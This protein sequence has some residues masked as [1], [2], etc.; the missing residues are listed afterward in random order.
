MEWT[1]SWLV[2]INETNFVAESFWENEC[3]KRNSEL[4]SLEIENFQKN[5][6]S[7]CVCHPKMP[8]INFISDLKVGRYTLI[9]NSQVIY[10]IRL[11]LSLIVNKMLE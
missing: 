10:G 7:K 8:R 4:G 9:F 5:I 2:R 3:H 6:Q 1:E 11:I